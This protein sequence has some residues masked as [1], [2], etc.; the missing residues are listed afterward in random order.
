MNKF[1]PGPW[2]ALDTRVHFPLGGG[3]DLRNCPNPQ[4]NATLVAAS[5]ELFDSLE[6]ILD[7]YKMKI[8][9]GDTYCELC[10]VHA[11][12]HIDRLGNWNGKIDPIKHKEDCCIGNAEYAI[13]K[14]KGETK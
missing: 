11:H 14:A 13:A 2:L 3:F 7:L 9:Q 1:T 12:K 8:N 10:E 4:A 6:N 5:P